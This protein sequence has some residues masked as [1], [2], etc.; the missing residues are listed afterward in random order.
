MRL[1]FSA[2][3]LDRRQYLA[4][5]RY[6]PDDNVRQLLPDA[7]AGFWVRTRTGVSHIELKPMTLRRRLTTSNSAS[8][9]DTIATAWWPIPAC[10]LPVMFQQPDAG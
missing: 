8:A 3:E 9:R 2:P 5:Q 1:D 7:R 10:G 6:L 4:G